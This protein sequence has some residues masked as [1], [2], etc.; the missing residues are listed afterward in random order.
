MLPIGP[1][2]CVD[3]VWCCS[4]G[5]KLLKFIRRAVDFD[6]CHCFILL[7]CYSTS[8]IQMLQGYIQNLRKGII[9]CSTVANL[10]LTNGLLAKARLTEFFMAFIDWYSGLACDKFYK[11]TLRTCF[12]LNPAMRKC[13]T[14]QATNHCLQMLK[15]AGPHALIKICVLIHFSQPNNMSTKQQTEATH[16]TKIQSSQVC[17]RKSACYLLNQ[18]KHEQPWKGS[19]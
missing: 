16:L 9:T 3:I 1:S 5:L 2:N 6:D 14:N 8:R 18:P 7:D 10:M 19:I 12:P 11:A 4:L 15:N 13:H 17:C